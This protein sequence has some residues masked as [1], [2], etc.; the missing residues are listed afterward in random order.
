[1]CEAV[2]TNIEFLLKNLFTYCSC[3]KTVSA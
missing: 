2:P 1:M 3:L